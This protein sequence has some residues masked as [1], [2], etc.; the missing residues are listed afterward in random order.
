LLTSL[1]GNLADAP[2]ILVGNLADAP[3]ILVFFD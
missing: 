2:V 1:A 3:V